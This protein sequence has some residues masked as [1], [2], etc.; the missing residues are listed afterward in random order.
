MYL[1]NQE[2][3]VV[4]MFACLVLPWSYMTTVA[5]KQWKQLFPVS[6]LAGR[7]ADFIYFF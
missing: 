6:D 4:L 2:I 3:F 7:F 5:N 1:I